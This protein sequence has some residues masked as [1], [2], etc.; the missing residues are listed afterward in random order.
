MRELTLKS[1]RLWITLL[2]CVLCAHDALVAVALESL[3]VDDD[4][5]KCASIESKVSAKPGGE[6]SW[7]DV[8]EHIGLDSLIPADNQPRNVTWKR[9]EKSNEFCYTFWFIDPYNKSRSAIL[10]QGCWDHPD[11]DQCS[12]ECVATQPTS[13]ETIRNNTRFCCCS[14]DLCN[15]NVTDNVN[16]TAYEILKQEARA[17]RYQPVSHYIDPSYRIR[18]IVI[19]LSSVLGVAI[20]IIASYA[21][22]RCCIL[23][24]VDNPH[25][26]L[27]DPESSLYLVSNCDGK[28]GGRSDLDFDDIKL[29][30]V[31]SRGRYG[32]VYRAFLTDSVI[33]VK[34]LRPAY[35][36]YYE[37]ERDIFMLP[38]MSHPA[39]V[40]YRGCRASGSSSGERFTDNL[41]GGGIIESPLQYIIVTSYAPFGSL[42]S[43]LKNATVSW[44]EL[45]VMA[46]SVVNGLAY[47]HTE[48]SEGGLVKPTIAHRDVNSRNILVKGD[49]T[50]CLCDFGFAMKVVTSRLVDSMGAGDLEEH[51][52][53]A[54]VGTL[55]Y[56]AP[57]VLEGSVNLYDCRASLTQVDI[58]AFGLVLWEIGTRCKDLYQ[59]LPTPEYKLPFELEVGS[60]PT[61]EEMQ[62]LVSQNKVRPMFPDT[63]KDTNPAMKSLKETIEDCWDQDAEARI[64]AVCV[65]ERCK[66]MAVLWEQRLKYI[67]PTSN[68]DQHLFNDFNEVDI[69]RE[70]KPL[71]LSCGEYTSSSCA[72][73]S[74]ASTCSTNKLS[75]DM[76]AAAR[77]AGVDSQSVTGD[78]ENSVS[79]ATIDTMMTPLS[80]LLTP[81]TTSDLPTDP[82]S[83]KLDCNAVYERTIAPHREHRGVNP[84]VARNTHKNSDEELSVEGNTLIDRRSVVLAE[85]SPA[86]ESLISSNPS[87]I[88]TSSFPQHATDSYLMDMI[89]L[90]PARD[91]ETSTSSGRHPNDIVGK[92]GAPG[93]SSATFNAVPN[94]DAL[95]RSGILQHTPP[96]MPTNQQPLGSRHNT[97]NGYIPTARDVVGSHRIPYTQNSVDTVSIGD[98]EQIIVRP[99]KQNVP[100]NG[101]INHLVVKNPK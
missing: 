60:N 50:C 67:M 14:G 54:E 52:S 98:Q 7:D 22:V 101:G 8:V 88:L 20:L 11:K 33:V 46:Q 97:S 78:D 80:N 96:M 40:E 10:L 25:D 4:V 83:S 29:D 73:A 77:A 63:W 16:L 75:C 47:L 74:S 71:S 72:S 27:L 84:T 59:G 87:H 39:I 95:L 43:Y 36:Q 89:A 56:M 30:S 76:L 91:L 44:S 19:A 93:G 17:N 26:H 3:S 61:F 2:A 32:E 82:R 18:T 94:T 66:E 65:E 49:R 90:G 5:S 45:C 28:S 55:R 37:N 99:K 13:R 24:P 68:L 12:S 53:L 41:I 23:P 51:T 42:T 58:Y 92:G 79:T 64:S 86:L 15:V 57:E 70:V 62:V 34:S 1:L 48:K 6:L 21:V 35:R 9:C 100:S 31:L 38:L 69:D 81:L 85:T